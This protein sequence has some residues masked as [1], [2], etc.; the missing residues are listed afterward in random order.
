MNTYTKRH[1]L[2]L[3]WQHTGVFHLVKM[4]FHFTHPSLDKLEASFWV[5]DL[6]TN[7]MGSGEKQLVKGLQQFGNRQ[8]TEIII[9]GL[10]ARHFYTIGIDYRGVSA[11]SRKFASKVLKE[12]YR[13]DFQKEPPAR[14]QNTAPSVQQPLTPAPVYQPCDPPSLFVKVEPTG[15][16]E[17]S[18]S[19]S[20]C[21]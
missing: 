21:C 14:V 6:G 15:Y 3:N 2:G 8:Q 13:Y 11:I 4:Q 5:K 19:P 1:A 17:D 7:L 20:I 10:K 12:S 9:E 18:G 16:C